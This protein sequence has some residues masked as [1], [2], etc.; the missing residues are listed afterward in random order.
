MC[1]WCLNLFEG[2]QK[3]F[4]LRHQ[5]RAPLFSHGYVPKWGPKQI[6]RCSFWFTFKSK[7]TAGSLQKI[8]NQQPPYPTIFAVSCFFSCPFASLFYPAERR[9]TTLS[10]LPACNHAHTHTHTNKQANKQINKQTNK[11]THARTHTHTHTVLTPTPWE[12]SWLGP[13]FRFR[14][15]TFEAARVLIDPSTWQQ[16]SPHARRALARPGLGCWAGAGRRTA[17]IDG[18]SLRRGTPNLGFEGASRWFLAGLPKHAKD[19]QVRPSR[20]FP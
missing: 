8:R 2:G 9:K 14:S 17:E 3:P 16:L 5:N 11:Q 1:L 18:P 12:K 15:W 13:R 10:R 20:E 7:V 4:E 6:L 19:D